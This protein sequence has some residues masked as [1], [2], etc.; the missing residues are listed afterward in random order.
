MNHTRPDMKVQLS[1]RCEQRGVELNERQLTLLSDYLALL[2]KW[3]RHLNLTGLRELDALIDVLII[4]SLDFL[5]RDVLPRPARVL[6]LGTGA[7]VPGIALAVCEPRLHLTLLD[8][9]QKKI[10]F[11]RRVVAQLQLHQCQPQ[12]VSAEELARRLTPDTRFDAVVTRGVGQ[13]A[14]LLS[15]TAPLLQPGGVLVLRKP[16]HT[17]ELQDAESQLASDTWGAVHTVPLPLVTSSAWTL[18]RFTRG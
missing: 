10:T 2:L 9:S 7:G 11:L 15:L 6:D 1:R 17:P 13:V 3:Q 4:E 16:P 14:H 5:Y 18:I 8:R 12:A